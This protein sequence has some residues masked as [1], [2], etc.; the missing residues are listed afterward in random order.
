[1]HHIYFTYKDYFPCEQKFYTR[2]V[3]VAEFH[4]TP[5]DTVQEVYTYHQLET[6]LLTFEYLNILIQYDEIYAD[7]SHVSF[8]WWDASKEYS[9]LYLYPNQFKIYKD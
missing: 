8:V 2:R 7:Y 4:N 3:S 9:D 1:M 5:N 6:L